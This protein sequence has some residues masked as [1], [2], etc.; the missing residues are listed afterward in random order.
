VAGMR[1]A[2]LIIAINSDPQTPIFTVAHYGA[3]ADLVELVPALTA[4]TLSE[5]K[6]L[7]G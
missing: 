5:K 3:V 7:H 1:D 4:A 6:V 2:K